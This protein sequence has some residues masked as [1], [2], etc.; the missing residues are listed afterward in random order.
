MRRTYV[1]PVVDDFT[2]YTPDSVGIDLVNAREHLSERQVTA[3]ADELPA[4]LFASRICAF[5][6]GKD[7]GLK[8]GA[9]A[10]NIFIRNGVREVKDAAL[11]GAGLGTAMHLQGAFTGTRT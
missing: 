9:S 1:I 10:L 4:N 6:A 3:E 2:S 7:A 11:Q 8:H 5:R